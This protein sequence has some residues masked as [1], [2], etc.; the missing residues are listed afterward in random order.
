MRTI[1]IKTDMR[2]SIIIC[3][4]K[5]ID[6]NKKEH[7]YCSFIYSYFFVEFSEHQQKSLATLVIYNDREI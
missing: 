5:A 1:P 3:Y 6:E 7:F 4:N 2:L